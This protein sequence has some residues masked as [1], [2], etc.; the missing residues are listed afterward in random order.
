MRVLVV[1]SNGLL[2]QKVLELFVR[3]SAHTVA[4]A[5]IEERAAVELQSVQYFPLDVTMKKDVR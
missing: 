3:G 2:G 4:A 5:S 1:G